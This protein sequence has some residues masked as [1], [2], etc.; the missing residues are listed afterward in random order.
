MKKLPI[1]T[2]EEY[3]QVTKK[4]ITHFN[5]KKYSEALEIFLSMAQYNASNFK[6]YEKLAYTYFHLNRL[7]EAKSSLEQAVLLRSKS[8]GYALKMPDFATTVKELP[9]LE[10]LEKDYRDHSSKKELIPTTLP[11]QIGLHYMAT[12]EYKKAE[13]FLVK[14]KL[15]TERRASAN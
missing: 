6:V 10:S 12:G 8:G 7:D 2:F 5:D 9:P 15:N 11:I 4:A 1:T 14:H 13:E 3:E